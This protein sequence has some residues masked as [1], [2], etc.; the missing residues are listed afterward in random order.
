M[1][2]VVNVPEIGYAFLKTYYQRM[3][4]DPSKV[5][6]LYSTTA[7]LTHVN[8]KDEWDLNGDE[9]P[10]VKLIGKEN[11]SKF[12]TRHSK[13][14]R[15]LQV[16]I[17]TCDFQSAG[18]NNTSIL[19][20]AMGEMCWADTPSFR[21][22]QI[23]QLVPV[24]SN[25]K[26]YDLTNDIL[27]FVPQPMLQANGLVASNEPVQSMGA[28]QSAA[29]E[30][31]AVNTSEDVSAGTTTT[32]GPA[33]EELNSSIGDVHPAAT[34]HPSPMPASDQESRGKD[35]Q[36]PKDTSLIQK[37]DEA[38]AQPERASEVNGT[39]DRP[40]EDLVDEKTEETAQGTTSPP[41]KINETTNDQSIEPEKNITS[42]EPT[43]K[44]NWALK[45]AA[46]ESKDV[47][48]VTTK[49]IRA[50]PSAPSPAKKV[51]EQKSVSPNALSRESRDVKNPKKKQFNLVNRDG[52]Y[53]IYVKGTGG[54]TDDQLVRAL[55]IEFGVV[56][57]I[58]S[59]ETFAVID[60]ED[61]RCQTEAIERGTLK[62]NNVE[63]HMEPKTVRKVGT[64]S[65][66]P[67]ST[68]SSGQ[69]FTKKHTKRKL[70]A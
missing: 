66:S 3:H 43:K 67:S 9:L 55:E 31:P 58:S 39:L 41:V 4:Q 32:P 10:T 16:K 64:P 12:Y 6:H 28:D 34:V 26:I 57:R 52:F 1:A 21:F 2:S 25:P 19:I 23:F 17:D 60:F 7:E 35:T 50:E 33:K 5:H 45:L 68:S 59:Q 70:N 15:S 13:K 54:V 44:M 29:Q 61:Q 36:T 62:V 37:P 8:Y 69:R 27:R 42:P 18:G 65:S 56:K 38:V 49:Y 20:L 40:V 14:V 24:P 11:I 46:S 48:N 63:V 53:P 30:P 51:P 22:C 47:P